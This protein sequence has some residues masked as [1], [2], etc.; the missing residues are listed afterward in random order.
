MVS[1]WVV[2][3]IQ[4]CIHVSSLSIGK[5][6]EKCAKF[7]CIAK[8]PITFILTVDCV[9]THGNMYP[10]E[11]FLFYSLFVLRLQRCYKIHSFGPFDETQKM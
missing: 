2:A 9:S 1:N 3:T 7:V 11:E 4:H 6:F 5:F 10:R 8:S